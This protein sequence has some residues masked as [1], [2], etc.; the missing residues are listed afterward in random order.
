MYLTDTTELFCLSCVLMTAMKMYTISNKLIVSKETT[1]VALCFAKNNIYVNLWS[2]NLT[3]LLCRKITRHLFEKKKKI[4]SAA[5]P[6][7][8]RTTQKKTPGGWSN[9]IDSTPGIYSGSNSIGSWLVPFHGSV[10]ALVTLQQPKGGESFGEASPWSTRTGISLG[11]KNWQKGGSDGATRCNIC[12]H[13][14]NEAHKLLKYFKHFHSFK[15]K[16]SNKLLKI[17]KRR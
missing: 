8:A 11:S 14:K 2:S 6:Y 5:R 4:S 1:P 17:L 9:W 15:Y 7:T 12:C 13:L 16:E 10:P 3:I